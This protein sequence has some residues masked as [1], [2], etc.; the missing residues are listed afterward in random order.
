M[1]EPVRLGFGPRGQ[2]DPETN[3]GNSPTGSGQAEN[4]VS[5]QG[6]TLT[7][8]Q[9]AYRRRLER[10]AE[11]RAE[12]ERLGRAEARA[13]AAEARAAESSSSSSAPSSS[14]SSS[15]R[16]A[17]SST[18]DTGRQAA[19]GTLAGV[20]VNK[21]QAR[22]MVLVSVA[23]L[24]VL[25]I[26]HEQR[27]DTKYGFY[28]RLWAT[29]AVGLFLA[30]LADFAPQVAGPMAGV[31]V[32]SQIPAKGN[33]L[34]LGRLGAGVPPGLRGPVGTPSTTP[35]RPP[36][37]TGPIGTQGPSTAATEAPGLTR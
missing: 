12:A 19:H 32:L 21:V 7:R 1:V 2:H 31:I 4:T 9:Q 22:K 37:V 24:V 17:A 25:N 36:G 11:R 5:D 27:G 30:V 3:R 34:L 13:E 14:S 26:I 33:D 20:S 8:G 16:R 28:R 18:V 29:G 10:E 6:D 15:P 35:G 23:V